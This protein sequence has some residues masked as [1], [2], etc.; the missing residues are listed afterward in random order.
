[1]K[2]LYSG[3]ANCLPRLTGIVA[4]I[5]ITCY[6]MNHAQS[7][8][9]PSFEEI[10]LW[11]RTKPPKET[12]VDMSIT[13]HADTNVRPLLRKGTESRF[14]GRHPYYTGNRIEAVRL[15]RGKWELGYASGRADLFQGNGGAAQLFLETEQNGL[16]P[17]TE[18]G[19]QA[20][21]NRSAIHRW[22]VAYQDQTKLKTRLLSKGNHKEEG[23]LRYRL[24]L[25][26]LVLQ[27]VQGGALA[28]RKR[29]DQFDGTLTL[30]T[31]RGLPPEV[32]GGRGISLDAACELV[33]S[34]GR[35]GFQVENLWGQL[36]IRQ[37]QL[38]EARIRVNQPI[39]DADGFLRAPPFLEGRV[40]TIRV[41]R[42][43]LPAV[44][45]FLSGKW[46]DIEAALL[47][48]Y[49]FEWIVGLGMKRGALWG[50]AWLNRPALQ[51]GYTTARWNLTLR[52][53]GLDTARLRRFGVAVQIVL[54][55][56]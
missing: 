37:A 32:V 39:P 13:H 16:N 42:R 48:R 20:T 54:P 56:R 28:G 22:T 6:S 55:L 35:L 41:A 10:P 8:F 12:C 26:W 3:K 36:Q 30:T 51:L 1:M 25:N 47:W 7:V 53:D 4:W 46:A 27:R 43:A 24:A 14:N 23:I 33:W 38:I 29:G 44:Q 11:I 9:L 5:G 15:H 49:D 31:T 52:L 17:N 18:Y 2:P 40:Q 34:N 21:L 19:V 50:I 45:G